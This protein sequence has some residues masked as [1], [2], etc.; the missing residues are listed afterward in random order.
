[1]TPQQKV[2]KKYLAEVAKE[3]I[4]IKA[5]RLAERTMIVSAR[6]QADA[7]G[8]RGV[9]WTHFYD[10]LAATCLGNLIYETMVKR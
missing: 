1:M 10:P 5:H 7:S 6:A 9:D 3:K 2:L 4:I 8:R